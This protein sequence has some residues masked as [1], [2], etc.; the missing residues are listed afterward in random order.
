MI[1]CVNHLWMGTDII[2][3]SPEGW[4]SEIKVLAILV[5]GDGCPWFLDGVFS[6]CPCMAE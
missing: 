3:H 6:L 2:L 5:S 1:L 4:D